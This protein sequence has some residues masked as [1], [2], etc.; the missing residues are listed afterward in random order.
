VGK[1]DFIKRIEDELIL[2]AKSSVISSYTA[3]ILEDLCK[4]WDSHNLDIM[5]STESPDK[6]LKLFIDLC[7]G[8]TLIPVDF[9]QD[10]VEN[11]YNNFVRYKRCKN[12]VKN[13]VTDTIYYANA[14]KI[15]CKKFYNAVF[16]YYKDYNGIY[17][18]DKIYLSKGGVVTNEYI[19]KVYVKGDTFM[20]KDPINLDCNCVRIGMN[21]RIIYTIDSRSNKLKAL[22]EFYEVPVLKDDK[23]KN[24]D[25]RNF[26]FKEDGNNYSSY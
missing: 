2:A 5:I 9:E 17:A 1:S 16:K 26:K 21:D 11:L 22:M 7:N 23:F 14:Y 18:P 20:P 4:T 25:L 12:L 19:E 15:V 13:T 8:K 3:K 6:I 24:I 10:E